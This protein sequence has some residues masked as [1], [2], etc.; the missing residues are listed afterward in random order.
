[1]NKR[2][3]QLASILRS[4]C[5]GQNDISQEPNSLRCPSCQREF[6]QNARID[7]LPPSSA[8]DQSQDALS[9]MKERVKSFSPG[10]YPKLIEL[11]SPVYFDRR[12]RGLLDQFLTQRGPL[13]LSLGSGCQ[14]LSEN[15]I[16]V[17]YEAYQGVDLRADI[18]QLPL[19]DQS[20]DGVIS[21]AVLEHVQN[22]QAV[23]REMYRILKPG[24]EGICFIP[25]MQGIHAS[26]HDYQRYTPAGL[27]ELFGS[28]E[29]VACFPSGGPTS[30]LLWLLQE[31]L[32]LALSFGSTKLYR[33]WYLFFF[34]FMPL[35]FL[36]ALLLRHPMAANISSGFTI[37]F[38]K[39]ALA[40]PS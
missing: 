26:P 21:L 6:F 25:F 8:Y 38:R 7:V 39:T 14:R 28:F 36:D 40:S 20:V 3:T 11:I 10:L 16:N 13:L 12:L 30:G 5:C 4:P 34:V 31:W 23:V 37:H 1:M 29:T 27:K 2:L 24:A 15:I 9:K 18:S 17:D 35:K 33:L 19:Q 22:P 32:S